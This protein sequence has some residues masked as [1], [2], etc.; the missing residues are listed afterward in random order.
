[1]SE[2]NL[3]LCL[4]TLRCALVIF[5]S[6]FLFTAWSDAAEPRRPN[7][8]LIVADDL[9]YADLSC[10]GSREVV[11]PHIDALARDGTRFTN[12]YVTC[13]VC[14]PSRAAILTGR[15]QQRFGFEFNPARA[16]HTPESFGLPLSE[17]TLADVL[18]ASN[19]K[20]GLVGKWHLGLAERFHPMRR[21]FDEFF[22]FLHGSHS[23]LYPNA[24]KANPI[25]H[26]TESV[27]EQEYLTDAFTREAVAFIN[28]H[29]DEAFFLFLSYSAVHSPM[30]SPPQKY[31]DRFIHIS[32]Q[33]RRTFAAMLA[34]M[35][36]GIG[37]VAAEL[38]KL[39]IEENT[40]IVFMSDNGGP[41]PLN[42]SRNDPLSGM[43]GE[44]LEG[45]IRVPLIVRWKDRLPAGQV[46]KEIVSSLDLFPTMLSVAGAR[47]PSSLSLDG[48]NMLPIIKGETARSPRDTLFWRYGEKWSA[49]RRDNWKLL[50]RGESLSLFDLAADP[51]EQHDV[52]DIHA[53]IAK[54]LSAAYAKWNQ[55]LA[56]P[57]WPPIPERQK[58][59]GG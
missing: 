1:M 25:L 22:G 37:A 6:A 11:T 51:T 48:I 46:S 28:R 2:S 23:Y 49:V 9:G 26:G 14:S 35:D 54:E 20:T 52:K 29:K 45:G 57:L 27:N 32:E 47:P 5:L 18:K 55:G 31:L 38:Q 7:I 17:K 12:A 43:K 39:R 53:E 59:I 10:Q 42:T 44:L 16:A 13:A 56:E 8:I 41:T 30:E 4:Q 15:Y 34:A 19:Y 3:F 36:D 50:R 33:R 58:E 24:E 21:G 40:L